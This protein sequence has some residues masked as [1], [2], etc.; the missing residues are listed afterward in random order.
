M[1]LNQFMLALR[2]RRKAFFIALLATIVTAVAVAMIVPKKY[3]ATA[4]LLMDSRDEQ[5]MSPARLSPRE[6]A[7]YLQTQVDLLLS[8]RVATK[9]ARELKI[10]QRPGVREAWEKDTGGVGSIDDWIAAGLIEK[11]DIDTSVSAMV[12]VN[13]YS[14]DPK[15]ATDVANGFAKAYLETVLSLRTEPTREAAEWFNDQMKTLRAQV[16]QAQ[17]KLNAYQKERGILAEDARVDVES[18]RLAELS[19]QLLAA[20]NALYD[21]TSRYQ[22][23]KQVADGGGSPDAI[24]EVLANIHIGTLKAD[25]GRAEARLEQ[26]SAVYGANHPQLQRTTAE[27]QGLREKLK[28]E[29]KRVVAGLGNAVETHRKREKELVSAIDAQNKRLMHL[30][31][32][33]IEMTAMS[34]DIENAQR[35]YDT[36]LTRYMNNRIDSGAKATNVQLLAPAI[37]PLKPVSPKVGLISGLSVVLG[38]MLAAGLVY[39]LETLDRRVRSRQDL[40]A[41]LA[42]P[43]L[44]RLSKWQPSGPRLLP[45]PIS[46]AARPARALPHP[47]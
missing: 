6:R 7:G 34:R 3:V 41:R 42:V 14:D 24:P 29:V 19:T 18:A 17:T 1:D 21:A 39:V 13:F 9:V 11:L 15:F 30:K 35:S 20:R 22:Q 27:V 23:A 4:T 44:G 47:W 12:L 37:E 5:T 46:S 2:A 43:S 8:N 26:E 45:A 28:V 10:A 38:A 25:L 32:F 36:V 31:D 33:R 40:E 16:V